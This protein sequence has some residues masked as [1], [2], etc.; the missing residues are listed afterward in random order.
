M[1]LFVIICVVVLSSLFRPAP[2]MGGWYN[3]P[4]YYRRPMRM[5][6]PMCRPRMSAMSMHH[7]H[8]PGPGHHGPRHW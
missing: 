8:G 7:M 3:S 2:Y 4:I 5:F 1:I 6:R